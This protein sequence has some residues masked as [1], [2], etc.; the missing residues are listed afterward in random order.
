MAISSAAVYA[1]VGVV[2]AA[3]GGYASYTSSEAQKEQADAYNKKLKEEAL[4]QYKEIDSAE[5]DAIYESHVESLQS[6][7]EF[8]Q[9]RSD[10]ALQSAFTG[11]YGTSVDTAIQD[12]NVGLGQRMTEITQ[13]RDAQLDSLTS[14]ASQARAG[15]DASLDRSVSLPSWYQA[16]AAGLSTFSR[17]SSTAKKIGETYR[18]SSTV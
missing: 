7:R 1:I 13:R 9:A 4:R 18:K 12:L 11:T 16:G 3:A 6:Q 2:S 10:I 8:L 17:T 14:A 15:A 5:A